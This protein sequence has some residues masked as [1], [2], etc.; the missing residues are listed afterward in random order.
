MKKLLLVILFL[1][2]TLLSTTTVI[3]AADCS[4]GWNRLPNYNKNRGGACKQ[5][6]LDSH[7]GICQPGQAYETL[8]DDSSGGKYR[9]CQGPRRCDGGGG[10]Y[11]AP[12]Q[13]MNCTHWDYKRNRPC[14]NGYLNNDCKGTC[15]SL[16]APQY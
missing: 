7:R 4:G 2:G 15:E 8:C 9:I 3:Y 10:N 12:P 5:M 1:C 11:N 14:P 16:P 6:G 13:N